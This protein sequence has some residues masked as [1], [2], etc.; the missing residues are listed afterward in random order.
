MQRFLKA[1]AWEMPFEVRPY[2]TFHVLFFTGSLIGSFLLAYLLRKITGKNKDRLLLALGLVL[3]V[4]ELYKQ[5]FLYYIDGN[6][7]YDWWYFPFQLCSLPIYFCLVIPFLKDGRAKRALYTFLCTFSLLGGIM[8]FVEPSGLIH[9]YWTWTLHS[10][11]WHSLLIFIGLL[12]GLSAEPDTL[13]KRSF[14]DAVFL[15]FAC[16][17]IALMLN[18]SLN[19]ISGGNI[20]MFY[21]NPYYPSEQIVFHDIALRVG[22]LPG[23]AVYLLSICLG[24]FL[25]FLI[26][27]KLPHWR[28]MSETT[29]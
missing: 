29:H 15:F 5:L 24:S 10:F 18:L 28:N 13:S 22:I 25:L 11:L 19:G 8:A 17:A 20:N 3:S 2:G 7:S 27:R 23:M 21:I 4:S 26:Q 6:K 14:L 12:A 1:T 9:P 16:A